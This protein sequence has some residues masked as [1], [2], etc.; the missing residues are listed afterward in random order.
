MARYTIDKE[1]KKELK[2]DM[3]KDPS[4]TSKNDLS[5]W[6]CKRWANEAC[7]VLSRSLF[8]TSLPILGLLAND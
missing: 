3:K 5:T 2:K 6:C 1:L 7:L 4:K 8:S